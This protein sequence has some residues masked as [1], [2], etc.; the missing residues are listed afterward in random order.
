MCS[1]YKLFL[2]SVK[3]SVKTSLKTSSSSWET[4]VQWE[5]IVL[6]ISD[7]LSRQAQVQHHCPGSRDND[8]GDDDHGKDDDDDLYRDYDGVDQ[9]VGAK[10]YVVQW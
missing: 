2:K 3:T 6:P 5:R 7:L 1:D 9:G 10:M 4:F 8:D